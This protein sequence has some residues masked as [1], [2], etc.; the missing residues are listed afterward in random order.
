MAKRT[1]QCVDHGLDIL[2]TSHKYRTLFIS[3]GIF[4][5]NS[6]TCIPSII[7]GQWNG[8]RRKFTRSILG[9]KISN[10]CV[11]LSTTQTD[12]W[13]D[14]NRHRTFSIVSL[15]KT[16]YHITGRAHQRFTD[17]IF[18]DQLIRAMLTPVLFWNFVPLTF[19]NPSSWLCFTNCYR[20]CLISVFFDAI[21]TSFL[22]TEK[23]WTTTHM[24]TRI[25]G[26]TQ[27]TLPF[28]D[29]FLTGNLFS[30]K[31]NYAS[32]FSKFF[33]G[34]IAHCRSFLGRWIRPLLRQPVGVARKQN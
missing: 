6:T 26:V 10:Y 27:R 15:A 14:D 3:T 12:R 34:Q 5:N 4:L 22:N 17:I 29:R 1:T 20:T 16:F 24:I 23:V 31:N 2:I 13:L 19:N 33:H 30:A 32:H 28:P 25:E 21:V 9:L 8:H 18:P 7:L 11:H